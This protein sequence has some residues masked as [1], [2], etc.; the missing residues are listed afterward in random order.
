MLE[1]ILPLMDGNDI[2]VSYPYPQAAWKILQLTFP[3][4]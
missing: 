1:V 4:H 2:N 3:I